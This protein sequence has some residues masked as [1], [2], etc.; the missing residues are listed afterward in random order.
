MP[1]VLIFA[2]KF[3]ALQDGGSLT[4]QQPMAARRWQAGRCVIIL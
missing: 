2:G 3:N 1:V 4:A